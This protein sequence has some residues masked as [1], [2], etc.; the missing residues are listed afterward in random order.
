MVTIAQLLQCA[1][2]EQA[3]V[4]PRSQGGAPRADRLLAQVCDSVRYSPYRQRAVGP[5][6]SDQAPIRRPVQ[7]LDVPLD[8]YQF[9][10]QY[11]GLH[12]IQLDPIPVS[13]CQRETIGRPNRFA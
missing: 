4:K 7:A 9:A 13:D 10:L 6:S 11:H 3:L 5:S 12:V 8:R 1:V 2:V